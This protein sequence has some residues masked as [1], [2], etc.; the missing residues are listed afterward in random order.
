MTLRISVLILL[1]ALVIGPA[2]RAQPVFHDSRAPQVS[3]ASAEIA[4]ALGPKR[5]T[6]DHGLR[7]LS[8][9]AS[10]L[11]FAIAAD[12]AESNALAQT[13]HVAPLNTTAPQAYAIRRAEQRGR[14]TIAVLGADANG[15]MY[16]GL[17]IAAAIRLGS[18]GKTGDSDHSPHIAQRGIKFNIP[19]D[20]RT[21]TYS[22]SS[23]S[24]QSNIAEMWS[25]DFWREL[26]DEMARQRFNTISLW[27]LHPFPS[28]VKVPEYPDVALN[29]VWGNREP[30]DLK[31]NMNAKAMSQPFKLG[32]VA[33]VNHLTIDD[34][35]RFWQNVMQYA[36]DRGIDM[37]WYTWNI[38]VWGTEGKHGITEDGKNPETT[39]TSARVSV[40]Q[41][42]PI[43]CLQASASPRART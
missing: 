4:R 22:D 16:G 33:I 3:F 26:F 25:M 32:Q 35:I 10:S 1:P 18:I 20:R 7:G 19:L 43:R 24:A 2:L 8:S 40:K 15:A 34:K 13:L 27:N 36:K 9:F 29:D 6:V 17:D 30:F 31:F 5:A 37:Y 23:D 41:S 42:R 38:F 28:I 39:L 12:A 14:V 21:P 11:R